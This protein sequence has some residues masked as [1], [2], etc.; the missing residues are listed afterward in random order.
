MLY[1]VDKATGETESSVEVPDRSRYGMSTWVHNGHQ[2]IILQTGPKLTAVA[3][4]T[5]APVDGGH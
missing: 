3:L 4:P 2:Y 5:A 1:A